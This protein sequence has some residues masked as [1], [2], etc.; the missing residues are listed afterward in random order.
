MEGVL[1]DPRGGIKKSVNKKEIYYRRTHSSDALGYW[2]S[3][4]APVKSI[5]QPRRRIVRV[6]DPTYATHSI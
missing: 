3:Y 1:I 4:E 2:I 5:I 6:K